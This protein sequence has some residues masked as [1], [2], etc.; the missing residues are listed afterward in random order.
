MFIMIQEGPSRHRATIFY[1]V[2]ATENAAC[3][4]V[5]LQFA[6][7]HLHDQWLHTTGPV[8]IVIGALTGQCLS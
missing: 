7:E 6:P 2:T 1:T 5:F 4:A 8:L 3:L